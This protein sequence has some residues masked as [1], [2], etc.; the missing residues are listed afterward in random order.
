ME[1]F[2][3]LF[4]SSDGEKASE[5]QRRLQKLGLKPALGDHDFIYDWNKVVDANEIVA[6]ADTI[7]SQLKG[8][9]VIL[10]F[11]TVR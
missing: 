4:L 1:T 10:R 9:G 6:F 5:I 11:T 2:V 3:D 8:T 7:Q